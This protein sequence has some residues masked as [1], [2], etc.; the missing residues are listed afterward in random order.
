MSEI[1][2]QSNVKGSCG[3]TVGNKEVIIKPGITSISK[4]NLDELKKDAGFAMKIQKKKY[5]ILSKGDIAKKERQEGKAEARIKD[6][7]EAKANF[8]KDKA[9]LIDK[10]KKELAR[11][12]SEH[13][14]TV[15]SMQQI[16]ADLERKVKKLTDENTLLKAEINKLNKK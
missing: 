16:K 7:E 2:L 12:S 13:Q 4:S 6:L 11:I 1:L 15:N 5:K 10:Q 8:K 9:D 3:Y 14:T